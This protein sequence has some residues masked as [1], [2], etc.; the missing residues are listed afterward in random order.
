MS[1]LARF[2][3]QQA[4]PE[5]VEVAAP[6][7]DAVGRASTSSGSDEADVA[8]D[9]AI[10]KG[11]VEKSQD[12][13]TEAKLVRVDSMNSSSKIE[14]KTMSWK[15]ATAL[16]FGE[17]VCLAILALP[18]SYKTLGMAGG[19]I[20]TAVL[21]LVTLYTSLTL[22]TYCNRHPDALHIADIGEKL[23]GG[24]RIAYEITAFAL[25]INN[26][27]IMGLHTL[28][29]SQILNAVSEHGT[30]TLV[31]TIVILVVCFLGTLPRKLEHVATMGI[32]SAICMAIAIL[33]VLIF[34]GIQGREPAGFEASDPVVIHAWAPEG[35]TFVQGFNAL[36]SIIFLWVGQALYPSFI[37]EMRDPAEFP[38]ALYALTIMEMSLFALV[39]AFVYAFAGQYSEAPAVIVLRPIYKKIAFAFVLPPT[40]I[41]GII[42][43]SVVAK[44]LFA[45]ITLGTKDYSHSTTKG[46]IIWIGCCLSTWAFG[47]VVGEAVP[48]FGDLLNLT[49]ALFDGWFG[50]IFWALAYAEI[51]RGQLWR[52]QGILRRSETSFNILIAIAGFFI[53]G[54]GLYT[55]VEGIRASYKTGAVKAPFSCADN[56]L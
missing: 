54:V 53:F 49:S 2:K 50:F 29:G 37:A 30:C 45:R 12:P 8:Q 41:I 22:S 4:E 6:Q 44:Y 3:K 1:L 7:P 43:A 55:S 10:A 14:Y 26:C 9:K 34:S 5:P 47:W 40:V 23:F 51:N 35:T 33:L 52:G 21:G 39:G 38:K 48:F 13:Y 32:G 19:L 36:L 18:A 56:S 42:Y 11:D 20:A 15:K 17:Y 28:T 46:W 27:F 16:L 24:S 31:F 25:I